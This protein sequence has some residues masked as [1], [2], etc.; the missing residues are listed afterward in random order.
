[1]AQ[2]CLPITKLGLAVNRSE[3]VTELQNTWRVLDADLDS[4][5]VAENADESQYAKRALVRA[6]F[7]QVEGLSYQLRQV[8][9]ASLRDTGQLSP[10]EVQLL[11]EVR[12][13]IDDRGNVREVT[14]Y[15]S[16]PDSVLFSMKIYV[17]NHG[18]K[19]DIDKN[20]PGWSAFKQATQTRHR[21]THPKNAA[22][23]EIADSDVRNL[24][25]ASS[26]WQEQLLAM[27]AAC[28]EADTYWSEKLAKKP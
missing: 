22:S 6:F 21:V 27:F 15:L 11:R 28:H 3:A 7:A 9:I 2:A 14:S 20:H 23:L 8:T 26:W 17:K 4:A 13:S 12:E 16:F 10:A 18:A 5:A 25:T 1:M 24:E 19:F